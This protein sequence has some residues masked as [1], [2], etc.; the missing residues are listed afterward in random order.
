MKAAAM[1]AAM[2]AVI[3][4]VGWLIGLKALIGFKVDWNAPAFRGDR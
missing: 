3:M 4:P 1:L 2:L